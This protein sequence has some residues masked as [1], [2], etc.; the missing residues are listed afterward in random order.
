MKYNI[1]KRTYWCANNP[2]EWDTEHYTGPVNILCGLWTRVARDYWSMQY[3]FNKQ[4]T[5]SSTNKAV[6]MHSGWLKLC[7]KAVLSSPGPPHTRPLFQGWSFC[8]YSAIM[9]W[10]DGIRLR[11]EGQRPAWCGCITTA[12]A[13]QVP[14]L[15]SQM[16]HIL[17]LYICI[18]CWPAQ[19]QCHP[20]VHPRPQLKRN[21]L[22]LKARNTE[23]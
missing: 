17:F 3:Y 14:A 11:S 7:S 5:T 19:Q 13:Q 8:V 22:A 20:A 6:L 1:S 16:A 23:S 9:Q 2:S 12:T 10:V 18:I 21:S 4:S 15:F